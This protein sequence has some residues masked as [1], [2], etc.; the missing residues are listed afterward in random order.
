MEVA[1]H[2]EETVR[3]GCQ[4]VPLRQAGRNWESSSYGG[5]SYTGR[6]EL[7]LGLFTNGGENVEGDYGHE[8]TRRSGGSL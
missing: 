4:K 7:F 5:L 3:A 2:I 1:H 8:S 6:L